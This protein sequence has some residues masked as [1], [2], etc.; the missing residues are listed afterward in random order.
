MV[1]DQ[2]LKINDMINLN[3]DDYDEPTTFAEAWDHPNQEKRKKWRTAIRKG[4][5]ET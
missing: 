1:F 4:V 3:L 5:R 2:I